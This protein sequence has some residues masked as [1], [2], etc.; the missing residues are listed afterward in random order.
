M[1]LREG[2]EP[3]PGY[4]LV[5]RLGEGAAGEVW[6]ATGPGRT[7]AAL[8]FLSLSEKNGVK[9]Y[10]ALQRVKEIRHANLL[11]IHAIWMLDE[12]GN[13]VDDVATDDLDTGEQPKRNV[14]ATMF[15]HSGRPATL[16]VAMPLGDKN[17]LDRL[18]EFQKMGAE[19]IP[20]RELL[21]VMEDAARGIDYLNSPNH[22]LGSGMVAIQ[23]RDIKPQNILLVG[24]S[25]AVC[26]FG[27]A[28]DV[29]ATHV[30]TAMAGTP[31]YI[32]PECIVGLK[33]SH[34]TDQYSL[35]ISYCELRTGE[36]PFDNTSF[37][38][39]MEAHKTGNLNLSRLTPG[40][41]KVILR[42]TSVDPD[43]RFATTLEMIRA[44]RGAVE[45]VAPVIRK[46]AAPAARK[47]EPAVPQKKP[48]AVP[49]KTEPAQERQKPIATEPPAAK[50]PAEWSP[51]QASPARAAPP[52]TATA[53]QDR[54]AGEINPALLQT[55]MDPAMEIERMRRATISASTQQDSPQPSLDPIEV[56]PPSGRRPISKPSGPVPIPEKPVIPQP[57]RQPVAKQAT[58]RKPLAEDRWE[59]PPEG[60]GDRNSQATSL[61]WFVVGI[62]A[63]IG[64]ILWLL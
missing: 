10:R 1:T 52:A 18:G 21:D 61:L 57:K 50:P 17:L 23:H 60:S 29:E 34:A 56:A 38:G 24:D 20:T 51:P 43:A 16:V 13:L 64:L 45:G 49:Q 58:P 14:A 31:A 30:S 36:L 11:P 39:V 3:V 35:A 32:A 42:A 53:A 9:E 55:M 54:P 46:S 6:K 8:K 26:D 40:E 22:D 62:A 48:P 2:E 41:R 63:V 44:L 12:R 59:P 28:R 4:R 15:M 27:L 19:G 7:N 33:P 47:T 25:A 37:V 5:R